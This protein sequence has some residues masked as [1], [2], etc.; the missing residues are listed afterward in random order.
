[1]DGAAWLSTPLDKA[2]EALGASPQAIKKRFKALAAAWHPDTCG[3]PQAGLVF[4]HIVALREAALDRVTGR[5]RSAR[6]CAAPQRALRTADG[7]VLGVRPTL[8]RATDTCSVWVGRKTFAFLFP[9]GHE[10]LALAARDGWS[11]ARYAD[12][13]MEKAFR[14]Y[15]PQPTR[16]DTP[17]E[18]GGHLL[19]IARP[20]GMV[21]LRDLLAHQGGAIHPH[22]V[23]WIGSGLWNALSWFQWMGQVHGAIGLD[24]VAVHPGTHA[25][26]VLGGW[27][28]MTPIGGRPKALPDA[29]L[30][31]VPRLEARG[32][33]VAPSTD[34]LLVREL[35]RAC[36]G[37]PAALRPKV[38]GLGDATAA[39]IAGP[40]L[41]GAVAE[42]KAWIE[43]LEKDDGPRRFRVLDADS[44]AIYGH[45]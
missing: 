14:P 10:D 25:V 8:E 15:A 42:Y 5:G 28:C 9:K 26:A 45:L 27:E 29:T 37:A 24:T 40:P 13:R 33:G 20:E 43:A 38:A 22:H 11:R 2:V 18:G 6:A 3:D 32:E 31:A 12:S 1:M 23:A 7:R 4:A 36:L 41:A 39:A 34:A 19:A 30:R 17:L 44:Q 35:L 16:L 21:W